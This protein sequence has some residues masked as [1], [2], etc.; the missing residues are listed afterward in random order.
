M[1]AMHNQQRVIVEALLVVEDEVVS[2][3]WGRIRGSGEEHTGLVLRSTGE[4]VWCLSVCG[5]G[6]GQR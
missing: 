1:H 3:F 5:C 6:C 2:R 4:M